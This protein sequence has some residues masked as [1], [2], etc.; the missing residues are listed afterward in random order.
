MNHEKWDVLCIKMYNVLCIKINA[1]GTLMPWCDES[2]SYLE[3]TTLPVC[4]IA[5]LSQ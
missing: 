5:K 3:Q 2:L 4:I 1:K